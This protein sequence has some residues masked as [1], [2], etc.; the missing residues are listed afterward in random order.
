MTFASIQICFESFPGLTPDNTIGAQGIRFLELTDCPFCFIANFPIDGTAVK[1][2][3]LQGQ[4]DLVRADI[5]PD[6]SVFFVIVR[7]CG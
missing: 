4:L 2:G 6:D 3:I 1:T 7:C 5:D